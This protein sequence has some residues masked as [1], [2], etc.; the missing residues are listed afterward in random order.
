MWGFHC[1]SATKR[2]SNRKKQPHQVS[3]FFCAG[4]GSCFNSC[5]LFVPTLALHLFL[6]ESTAF[7]HVAVVLPPHTVQKQVV[8]LFLLPYGCLDP[9]MPSLTS[10]SHPLEFPSHCLRRGSG[11]CIAVNDRWDSCPIADWVSTEVTSL[12]QAEIPAKRTALTQPCKLLN[13]S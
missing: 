9:W 13:G 7:L 2:S 12:Q 11:D 3:S 6:A 8:L 5:C 1:W 4:P 10:L